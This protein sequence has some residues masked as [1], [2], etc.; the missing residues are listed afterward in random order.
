MFLKNDKLQTFNWFT[1]RQKTSFVNGTAIVNLK[2]HRFI[3]E[4]R[5]CSVEKINT[6]RQC[7]YHR[8]TTRFVLKP[9]SRVKA[10]RPSEIVPASGCGAR[11]FGENCSVSGM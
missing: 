7:L 11:Y 1:V 10:K 2:K 5:F 3:P 6:N 9:N 8:S 4:A